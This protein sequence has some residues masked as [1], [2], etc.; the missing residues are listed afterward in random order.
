MSDGVAPGTVNGYLYGAAA[1][2]KMTLVLDGLNAVFDVYGPD[3]AALGSGDSGGT[4]VVID[5]LPANGD[6]L[7]VVQSVRGGTGFDLSVEITSPSGS[8]PAS[9]AKCATYTEFAGD[10]PLRICHK[11]P[12]VRDVQQALA[13]LGYKVDVD[14]FFGPGTV[15]ALEDYFDDGIAELMP[16][17]IE[18]L[19][20][21]EDP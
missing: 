10:Y 5:P 20:F 1:G 18:A 13:D 7:V 15:A 19:T 6:Y 3:D 14:G 9:A 16:P 2:Q 12:L 21:D 17:D 11:G 8:P 4:P